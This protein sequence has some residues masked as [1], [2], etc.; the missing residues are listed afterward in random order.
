MKL[1]AF[2]WS[3]AWGVTSALRAIAI[4][5]DIAV[6]GRFARAMRDQPS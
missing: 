5:L 3:C 1:R 6:R 4:E 2:L